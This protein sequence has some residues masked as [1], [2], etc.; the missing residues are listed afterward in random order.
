MTAS[1]YLPDA[2]DL[3]WPELD[4]ATVQTRLKLFIR[5][6]RRREVKGIAAQ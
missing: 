1:A 4:R 2:G 3:I 5:S 6:L